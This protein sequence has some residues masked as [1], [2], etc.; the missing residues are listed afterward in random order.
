MWKGEKQR[1]SI[2]RRGIITNK[3]AIKYK[4]Q[5]GNVFSDSS[6]YILS[7]VGEGKQKYDSGIEI[8]T[9]NVKFKVMVIP[10]DIMCEYVALH[11][12][13]PNNEL[14][15]YLRGVI[16]ANEVWVREDFFND[17]NKFEQLLWHETEE[18]KYM[19][20][21][22]LSY[23]DA[24]KLTTGKEIQKFGSAGVV[25]KPY[26]TRAQMQQEKLERYRLAKEIEESEQYPETQ[27]NKGI[28]DVKS[29]REFLEEKRKKRQQEQWEEEQFW[30]NV[31]NS[32]AKP[33]KTDKELEIEDFL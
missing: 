32:K 24:H 20:K 11:G 10:S 28:T 2:S 1:H 27:Q 14:P 33:I 9:H 15:M 29:H 30:A 18:L 4:K 12:L 31:G 7:F 17:K 19:T 3:Q 8:S 26:L 22:N 6:K 23:R 25:E 16:P 5:A 13:V 21:N